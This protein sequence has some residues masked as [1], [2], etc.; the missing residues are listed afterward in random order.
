MPGHLDPELQHQLL[1]W[2][3]I[4]H[5]AV[6]M[7]PSLNFSVPCYFNL[8]ASAN[9]PEISP[10]KKSQNPP[11]PILGCWSAQSPETSFAF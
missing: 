7:N 1:F 11:L 10:P 3:Q 4:P 9:A 5:R 8:R 2:S 6:L